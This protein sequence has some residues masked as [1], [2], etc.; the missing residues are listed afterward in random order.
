MSLLH[1]YN[2]IYEH[3]KNGSC[4]NWWWNCRD[5]T[6]REVLY[7]KYYITGHCL[8]TP[9]EGVKFCFVV[10]LPDSFTKDSYNSS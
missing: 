7:L 10:E 4:S 5:G 3:G 2:F 6:N 9:K 1:F 8:R